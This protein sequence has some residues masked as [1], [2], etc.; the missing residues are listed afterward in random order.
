MEA[1]VQLE[2]TC[3]PFWRDDIDT[4]QI[5]PARFLKGTTRTGYGQNL[6]YDWR[7]D[8][9]GQLKPASAS[10]F[11]DP[12]YAGAQILVSGHNF[13]CGSSREHAPW[14]LKDFGFCVVI[15]VSF[16]DI[17]Y[18]NALKNSL[19]PVALPKQVVTGLIEAV[20]ADAS[21]QVVVDLATQ[22][23]QLP[24]G[25]Q[26]AFDINPFRKQCLLEGVDDVGF[27]LAR[28]A[29]IEAWEAARP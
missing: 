11:N 21:C 18:N 16:A 7:Y 27:V 8:E 5:I 4:D 25:A 1:F 2:S 15:A 19:L 23:V 24:G 29:Q 17:F 28:L 22:Q 26:H 3:M 20:Q 13:G 6:F 9:Q 12:R 14:A 10:V